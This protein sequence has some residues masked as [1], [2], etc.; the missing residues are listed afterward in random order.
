MIYFNFS[1]NILFLFS[2]LSNMQ[3]FQGKY[4]IDSARAKWWNY[5]NE[6]QYF[7]TINS[8]DFKHIFGKIENGE[9]ILNDAGKIVAQ[10]WNDLP[11]HYPN[12]ILD[13]FCI[14]PNHV[15]FIVGVDN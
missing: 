6:G 14:M 8:K 15:H 9:M 11:K 5:A 10:C 7:I 12:I 13:E 4:R 1:N 3:K 2:K